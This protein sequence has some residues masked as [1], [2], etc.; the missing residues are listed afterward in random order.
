MVESPI[1]AFGIGVLVSAIF[2]TAYFNWKWEKGMKEIS[3]ALER[4]HLSAD[5]IESA[6]KRDA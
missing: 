6:I 4:S 3:K 1:L 5:V 2:W